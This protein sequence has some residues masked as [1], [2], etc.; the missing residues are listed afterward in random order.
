MK[1]G[2]NGP[3]CPCASGKKF[4]HYCGALAAAPAAGPA[5]PCAIGL[6][7]GMVNQGHLPEAQARASALLRAQPESGV[8]WKVLEGLAQGTRVALRRAS[9][10]A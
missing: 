9:S 1:P 5:D 7:V 4:K 2:R 8:L 10:S 3:P 6:L